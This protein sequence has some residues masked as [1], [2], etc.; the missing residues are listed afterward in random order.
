M[1]VSRVSSLMKLCLYLPLHIK[2]TEKEYAIYRVYSMEE[3]SAL[4]KICSGCLKYVKKMQ[5]D[6]TYMTELMSDYQA[7]MINYKVAFNPGDNCFLNISDELRIG[8]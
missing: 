1:L 6:I 5:R 3:A 4:L 8:I 7:K 2:K